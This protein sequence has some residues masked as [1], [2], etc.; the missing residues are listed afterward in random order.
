MVEMVIINPNNPCGT[1]FTH[2]HLAKVAEIAKRLGLLIISDGVY[3]HIVFS[4]K[5]FIPMGFFAS[6]VPVI[7]LGSISKKWM[8]P[9][10][11]IGWIVTCDL[12]GIMRKS[13]ITESIIATHLI[14]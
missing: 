13:Q 3:A 8:V 4:E 12:D 6:T 2:D 10:W 11:W 14:G 7:T 5:P 1:T 9:G